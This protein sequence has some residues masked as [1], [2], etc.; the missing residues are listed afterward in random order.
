MGV[1]GG[2]DWGKEDADIFVAVRGLDSS[3]LCGWSTYHSSNFVPV[4]ILTVDG[5]LAYYPCDFPLSVPKGQ[6]NI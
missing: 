6:T 1:G 2:L 3:L 4:P 5:S